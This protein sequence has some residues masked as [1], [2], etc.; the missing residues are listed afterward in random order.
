MTLRSPTLRHFVETTYYRR[1]LAGGSRR[2]LADY[3]VCVGLME[4]YW[5]EFLQEQDQPLRELLITDLSDALLSGAMAWRVGQGRKNETA[6]KLLRSIAAIWNLAVEEGLLERPTKCKPYPEIH[7]V[8]ICWSQAELARLIEAAETDREWVA[9]V[10]RSTIYAALIWLLYNTGSRIDAIMQTPDSAE[11]LSLDEKWILIKGEVQKGKKDQRFDLMPETINALRR[12]LAETE[13]AYGETGPTIFAAWPYDRT[14][15]TDGWPALT[16]GLKKILARA[17]LPT[18]RKRLFH[19]VRKTCL[20]FVAANA[21]DSAAQAIGGHSDMSTTKRYLDPRFLKR[22]VVSEILPK[23]EV[24]RGP[25]LF[26]V[27]AG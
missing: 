14:E 6:N 9:G 16:G 20:T 7:H 11:H 12:L 25:R 18:D 5:P 13:H 15:K 27:D 26:K 21:G 2:T 19:C 23:P 1:R 22:P 4:K 10:R 17:G 8:P 3:L 24:Q